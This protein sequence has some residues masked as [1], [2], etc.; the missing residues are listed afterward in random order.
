MDGKC[1]VRRILFGSLLSQFS[2]VP[3]IKAGQSFVLT[4]LLNA[5]PREFFI[6][7]EN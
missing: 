4:L 6:E 1:E 2:C 7:M 3:E 5:N